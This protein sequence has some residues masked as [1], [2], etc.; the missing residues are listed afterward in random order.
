MLWWPTFS[1]SLHL[2]TLSHYSLEFLKY[3]FVSPDSF[4]LP[5]KG[6]QVRKILY[7]CYSEI[8]DVICCD[9]QQRVIQEAILVKKLGEL[10]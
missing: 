5:H 8:L 6:N 4:K 2:L 1:L 10:K 9:K 7:P 3:F